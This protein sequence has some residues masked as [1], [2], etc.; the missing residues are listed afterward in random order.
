V[1]HSVSPEVQ[2]DYA[3][4]LEDLDNG[5]QIIK[6]RFGQKKPREEWDTWIRGAGP[7]PVKNEKGWLVLYHATNKNEPHKYKLGALL[8]D[9]N[10]PN[11]ILA[12]SSA[13]LLTSETWYENDWKPGVVYACGATVK[14]GTLYVYYGGGDKHVCVAHTPLKGLLEWLL[15]YGK[16]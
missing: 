7:S 3:D 2:I 1:L 6:S 10:D 9:I 11:K 5:K 4:R 12:R 16:V 13:P 14:E 15:R 8:L